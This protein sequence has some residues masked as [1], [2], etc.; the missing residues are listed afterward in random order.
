MHVWR[1]ELDEEHDRMV[2]GRII[3]FDA[4]GRIILVG[5]DFVMALDDGVTCPGCREGRRESL[6]AR[7]MARACWEPAL[8][9]GGLSERAW[10]SVGGFLAVLRH[11][12]GGTW[13]WHVNHERRTPAS[14]Q[15]EGLAQAA[16]ICEAAV[17]VLREAEP[18]CHWC[19][20]RHIGPRESDGRRCP[21][22]LLQP[23]ASW[24]D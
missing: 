2:C 8:D 5:H 4:D 12:R 17:G 14:G 15:A 24:R 1:E 9:V 20:T 11:V 19:E 13:T 23:D 7:P 10:R 18:Y 3:P 22:P 6:T 21:G 16:Q